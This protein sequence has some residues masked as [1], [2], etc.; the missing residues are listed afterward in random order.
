MLANAYAQECSRNNDMRKEYLF[1]TFMAGVCFKSAGRRNGRFCTSI[2]ASGN[3]LDA[4]S[5][6]DTSHKTGCMLSP[7]FF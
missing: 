6:T 2:V 7:V 5:R 1:Y 4:V 3:T